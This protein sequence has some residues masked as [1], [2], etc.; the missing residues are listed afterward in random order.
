MHVKVLVKSDWKS[1]KGFSKQYNTRI[2]SLPEKNTP[3]LC[4]TIQLANSRYCLYNNL[5]DVYSR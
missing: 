4:M 1:G 2:S 5:G 3:A